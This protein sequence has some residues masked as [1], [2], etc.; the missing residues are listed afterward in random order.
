[1]TDD[2]LQTD[3]IMSPMYSDQS[4]VLIIIDHTQQPV[5]LRDG[6]LKLIS[7]APHDNIVSGNAMDEESSEFHW[8][9]K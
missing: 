6:V 1:M 9:V 3:D 7:Y 8:H 5:E 4:A 2:Y